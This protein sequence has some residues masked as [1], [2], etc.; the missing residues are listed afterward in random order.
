MSRPPAPRFAFAAVTVAVLLAATG[1]G[2]GDDGGEPAAASDSP[3]ATG[4][5]ATAT[6]DQGA[7]ASSTEPALTTEPPVDTTVP[8]TSDAPPATTPETEAETTPATSDEPD[9]PERRQI[10]TLGEESALAD[11]LALG[12]E[13]IASSATVDTVGFQGIDGYDTSNIEVLPVVTLS[14]EHLAMLEPEMIIAY[15]Y[16]VDSVGRDV[17]ESMAELVVLPSGVTATEQITILGDALDRP[18][19]A[20]DLVAEFDAALATGSAS[21]EGDCSTTVAAIYAGPSVAAFVD[22]PWAVPDTVLE[23][24]CALDPDTSDASPDANGRAY[25]SMEQLTILDGPQ[26]ILMQTDTVDGE[27]ASVD[28]IMANPIWNQLPAVQA[29]AVTIL[30]RLGYPGIEGRIRLAAELPVVLGAT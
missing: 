13:P 14:L 23:L 27:Q 4:D 28:E 3:A 29:D 15:Q 6:T 20:A 16:V 7:P 9:E 11:I 22:G 18:E 24:G 21:I 12:V 10:V 25:L 8:T 30:D 5:A 19:R 26:M 17:L 1:C 2:S